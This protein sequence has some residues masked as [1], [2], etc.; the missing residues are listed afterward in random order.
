MVN[1]E[2]RSRE[3]YNETMKERMFPSPS[4]EPEPEVGKIESNMPKGYE[5]EIGV[6]ETILGD[7]VQQIF[8]NVT[9]TEEI[10]DRDWSSWEPRIKRAAQFV[11]GNTKGLFSWDPKVIRY[12]TETLP[13]LDKAIF[14][15]MRG[16]I[17]SREETRLKQLKHQEKK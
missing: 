12:L 1:D 5:G 6:L 3:W 9:I 4:P 2:G 13:P 15:E 10:L 16:V 8:G 7:S 17:S 11:A 14:N